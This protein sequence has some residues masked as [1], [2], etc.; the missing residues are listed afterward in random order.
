[1]SVST[2]PAAASIASQQA[3]TRTTLASEFIKQNAQSQVDVANLLEDS[4]QNLQQV[5][6]SAP[7]GLGSVV[8]TRA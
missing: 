6:S 4:A 1:M 7:P 8:N 2:S 5:S 3:Q